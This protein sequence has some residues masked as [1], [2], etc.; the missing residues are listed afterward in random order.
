M[1][2]ATLHRWGTAKWG[3][4]ELHTNLSTFA[5]TVGEAVALDYA[6]GVC[7]YVGDASAIN[8]KRTVKRRMACHIPR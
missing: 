8:G 2:V 1:G 6:R 4:V 7:R 5:T 3:L